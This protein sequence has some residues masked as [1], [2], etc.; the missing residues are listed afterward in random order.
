[1]RCVLP[2]VFIFTAASFADSSLPYTFGE[3]LVIGGV[4]S[5]QR[6]ALR[7]DAIEQAVVRGTFAAPK[8]GDSVTAPDGMVRTWERVEKAADADRFRHQSLV[9]GYV[10]A[11][12]DS[13]DDRVVLLD[14][15]EHGMVYVNGVPRVGDPYGNGYSVLPVAL[16]KGVNEFLFACGRG[17]LSARLVELPSQR[18]FFSGVDDTAPVL[19]AGEPVDAEFGIT[20]VNPTSEPAGTLAIELMLPDGTATVT[21]VPVLPPLSMHKARA[22]LE[23]RAIRE[24]GKVVVRARILANGA[25]L[26]DAPATRDLDVAVVAP[27]DRRRVTFVSDID[28]SVQYYSVVPPAES[29]GATPGLILSLHGASVEAESQAAAY[30]PKPFA[31][32]VCPT[33]RRPFG[34]DWEDWGRLDALEVLADAQSRFATDPQRQWLTG[35]SMGGHGTWQLGAH[36]PDQFA[37]IAPSAGWISFRTYGNAPTFAAQGVEGIFGRAASPSE[38]LVLGRNY[39]GL[40]VYVLHGDADDNVPVTQARA[41]RQFL[42]TPTADDSGKPLERPG[43]DHRDFAYHERAGAGH[44]WGNECV[45]WPPLIDFLEARSLPVPS[46]VSTVEFVTSA[47][48]VSSTNRWVT[49]DQQREPMRPSSVRITRTATGFEGT[50]ANVARLG[51]RDW[52]E[53]GKPITLAIDG[54]TL[55]VDAP[56]DGTLWLERTADGWSVATSPAGKRA[57]RGGPFKDAFRNN[58][59]FVYGTAGDDESDAR[60]LAKARYDAETWRYRGNGAVEIVADADIGSVEHEGRNVVLFGNA[61]TNAAWNTLLGSSPVLVRNGSVKVGDRELAGE[62][63]ACVFAYPRADADGA[64]VAVVAGTGPIGDRV[65]WRLPYFVSGAGFPDLVVFDDDTLMKGAGAVRLAGFFGNDWSVERGEW[66][67]A[68]TLP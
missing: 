34:F 18:P 4:S 33:N 52:P 27:G 47:P 62:D 40:G 60:L 67:A 7:L 64:M 26:A 3:A 59:L 37:A 36:F 46:E 28:G 30:A 17:G 49:V 5:T 21:P 20:L 13:P 53:T 11:T 41:M 9:G 57:D 6:S 15:R 43:A 55:S 31:Y 35:H 48:W 19:V 38:T 23:G 44:W 63:L 58:M 14:A 32:V 42:A 1:M 10:F 56:K 45:D 51:L 66:A 50:T 65:T 12:Y 25:P 54:A 8:A 68:P 16:K 29:T 24:P 22:S 2:V 61:D 39:A